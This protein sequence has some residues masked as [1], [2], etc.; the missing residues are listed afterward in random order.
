M[1]SVERE[2]PGDTG[3]KLVKRENDAVGQWLQSSSDQ[4][5]ATSVDTRV[6]HGGKHRVPTVKPE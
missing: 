6:E 3:V 4:A 2:A 5:W 1:E